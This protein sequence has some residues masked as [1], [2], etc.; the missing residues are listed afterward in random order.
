MPQPY[1]DPVAKLLTYTG[2][3]HPPD[4]WPDYLA[5]GLGREHVPDLIR[6]ATDEALNNADGGSPEVWA[7]LH[8][9]R[10]LGQLRAEEAA[11]PLLSLF[12]TDTFSDWITEEL[13]EVFGMIGGAAIAPLR[14]FL[15]DDA[16]DPERRIS[17]PECL[18]RIA[19]NHPDH[20]DECVGALVRQ[21][22]KH[23]T[24]AGFLNGFV[25]LGLCEIGATETLG[26]IRQAYARNCVDL[27]ILGDVED[28]EIEMGVRK[29]R[30]TPRPRIDV[31]ARMLG[32]DDIGG[33][34]GEIDFGRPP[35]PRRA[36]KVGRN[37]PCPC[38]TDLKNLRSPRRFLRSVIRIIWLR[39]RRDRARAGSTRSAA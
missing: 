34:A 39:L 37:D 24:D 35:P 11:R 31:F 1:A 14:D 32:L 20:R 13:P 18:Q 16:I 19:A 9:W 27:A 30:S 12:D 2:D 8:A 17:I 7:P 28:A 10:A 25:V 23:D 6:M 33:V 38:I 4:P 3:G 22:E 5:L 26:V 29:K 36:A 21:L 15:A